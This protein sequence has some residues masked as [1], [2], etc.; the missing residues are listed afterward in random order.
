MLGALAD[1]CSEPQGL[2]PRAGRR[3]LLRTFSLAWGPLS[4]S[5]VGEECCTFHLGSSSMSES[6][7]MQASETTSDHVWG[8]KSRPRVLGSRGTAQVL[9]VPPNLDEPPKTNIASSDDSMA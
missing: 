9:F 8:G 3:R 1:G 4:Q 7:V 5:V 2:S 6:V